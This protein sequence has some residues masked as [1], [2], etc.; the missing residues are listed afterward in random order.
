[1]ATIL[2]IPAAVTVLAPG[3]SVL[4]TIAAAMPAGTWAPMTVANQSAMLGI[5]SSTGSILPYCNAFPWNP[6]NRC[7]EIIGGDHGSPTGLRHV[8]YVEATNTFQLV[9]DTTGFRGHGYDHTDVNPYTGDVYHRS[10][11]ATGT[12]PLVVHR[13]PLGQTTAWVPIAGVSV[14]QIIIAGTCWWS[15]PFTGGQGLGAQGG[16]VIYS[17][18]DIGRP[19]PTDGNISIYDPVNDSWRFSSNSMSPNVTNSTTTSEYNQVMAYSSVKNVAVYGG[20]HANEQR[21]WR[22][23]ANGNVTELTA[24]PTAIAVGIH[25]GL[26]TEDPV[27]GNFLILSRDRLY[28]LNPDG[29]GTWTEQTG[30]RVPPQA[31]GT[32]AG[33]GNRNSVIGVPLPDHGITAYIRQSNSGTAA[34]WLYKHA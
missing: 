5:G 3:S 16:F 1:M 31:V 12:K 20:G 14:N 17:R 8:R 28:E 19:T 34:F 27:T 10:Y 4:S 30:N 9:T 22:L 2:S 13:L 18:G 7:I 15:G 29:A 26:L 25:K 24:A 33:E 11:G 23:S 21:L 6:K 32:P